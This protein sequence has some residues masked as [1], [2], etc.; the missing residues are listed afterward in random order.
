MDVSGAGIGGANCRPRA[1]SGRALT[2]ARQCERL[3][4]AAFEP[5]ARGARDRTPYR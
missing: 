3:R 2:S 4:L 5:H 1:A